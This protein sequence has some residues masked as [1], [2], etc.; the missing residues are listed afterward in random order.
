MVGGSG[1]ELLNLHNKLRAKKFVCEWVHKSKRDR[2][3]GLEGQILN[4]HLADFSKLN[5]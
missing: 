5:R 1:G 3:K 2:S 4:Y